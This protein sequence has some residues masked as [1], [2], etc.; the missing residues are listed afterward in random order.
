MMLDS[1]TRASDIILDETIILTLRSELETCYHSEAPDAE[2]DALFL[3][4]TMMHFHEL[5]A[6]SSNR[7]MPPSGLAL[8]LAEAALRVRDEAIEIIRPHCTEIQ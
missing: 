6:S 2:P 3:A 7:D 8:A 5:L 4:W 1:K